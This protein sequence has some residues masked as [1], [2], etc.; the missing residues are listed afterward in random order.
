MPVE[1]IQKYFQ[2]QVQGMKMEM[3][4]H[5][6]ATAD[7]NQTQKASQLLRLEMDSQIHENRQLKEQMDMLTQTETALKIRV[8]QLE[9]EAEHLRSSLSDYQKLSQQGET[10]TIQHQEQLSRAKSDL[11]AAHETIK[12]QE[13]LSLEQKRDFSSYRT[14]AVA[15]LSDLKDRLNH[16][17]D[18]TQAKE[19]ECIMSQQ[20]AAILKTTLES[21]ESKTSELVIEIT[22]RDDTIEAL[23]QKH[24]SLTEKEE[25]ALASLRSAEEMNFRF[26]EDKEHLSAEIEGFR[27]SLQESKGVGSDLGAERNDLQQQLT[28][29]HHLTRSK[30]AQL[31]QAEVD[32]GNRL[33][34]AQEQHAN[35]LAKLRSDLTLSENARKESQAKLRQAE[36]VEKHRLECHEQKYNEKLNQ[37][38]AEANRQREKE[39]ARHLREMEQ[40]QQD[41]DTRVAKMVHKTQ[42]YLQAAGLEPHEVL[43]PN[44]QQ[45]SQADEPAVGSQQLQT[46]RIR[47]K[48]DRQT[49][50]MANLVSSSNLRS[51]SGDQQSTTDV[52]RATQRRQGGRDTSAGFFEEEYENR[53]GPQAPPH[54]QDTQQSV[55]EPG[56]EVVPETQDF[57]CAQ[58]S[59]VT[60]EMI[61]T[62]LPVVSN[63]NQEEATTDLSNMPSEDLSEMLL[64]LQSGSE[65]RGPDSRKLPSPNT[66]PQTPVR[67]AR[68]TAP[69]GASTN[70]CDRP[71]SRANT[72]LRMMPIPATDMQRQYV[73]ADEAVQHSTNTRIGRGLSTDVDDTSTHKSHS[74]HKR[75]PASSIDKD[76][77]SKKLRVH[78][79][80]HSQRPLSTSKCH[81]PD[82]PGA[83][84]HPDVHTSP[85]RAT[86][87]RG[88]RQ[89]VMAGS[90][91]DLPRLSSTRNTR[92][93]SAL[94]RCP[95]WYMY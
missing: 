22:Q 51:N 52:T 13:R 11:R 81:T 78:A 48:V 31:Q 75:K 87:R 41:V 2:D 63:L 94:L 8:A 24:V 16:M 44:T 58:G 27:T 29:L 55:I 64:D 30:E 95:P 25:R 74:S 17:S 85:S 21:A 88:N 73:S 89:T 43:V 45:S 93:K 6:E 37:L 91:G 66:T 12:R 26:E 72:A 38:V 34:Q 92:S 49:N 60:F 18:Q 84:A 32:M 46:R 5:I 1:G 68:D 86:G 40:C 3:L 19:H 82:A 23:R 76:V 79:Q 4:R 33:Q 61:D 28:E 50:S 15:H 42:R 47:K 90:Q 53:Y 67:P 36:E 80:P 20:N 35:E 69:D 14:G 71:K 65:Q 56:A 70:S 83:K 10:K 9:N 54:V 39:K 57:E 62:Q 59:A 7:D 77:S